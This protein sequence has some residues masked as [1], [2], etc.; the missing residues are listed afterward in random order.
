MADLAALEALTS[1]N[2]AIPDRKASAALFH[3]SAQRNCVQ[4]QRYLLAL[5]K[6]NWRREGTEGVANIGANN[7]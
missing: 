7:E 6:L 1:T 5:S 4:I 3:R 2:E